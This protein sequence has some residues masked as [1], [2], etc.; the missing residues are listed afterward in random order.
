MCGIA[1]EDLLHGD[2]CE[3]DGFCGS[4]DEVERKSDFNIP[5]IPR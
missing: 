2:H 1:G 5:Q 3:I 4:L